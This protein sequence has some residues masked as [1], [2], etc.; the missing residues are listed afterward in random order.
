[1]GV[2]FRNK[3]DF[4]P[5]CGKTPEI[6]RD[7]IINAQAVHIWYTGVFFAASL[8][9]GFTPLSPLLVVIKAQLTVL[10]VCRQTVEKSIYCYWVN[11]QVLG[12]FIKGALIC[13]FEDRF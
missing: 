3:H 7:P 5:V 8:L 13:V 10:Q 2:I 12:A 6:P 1:M 11:H 4:Y 9:G